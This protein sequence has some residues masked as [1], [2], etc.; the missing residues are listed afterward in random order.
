[1]RVRQVGFGLLRA[2]SD[3]FV[4]YRAALHDDVDLDSK[5]NHGA[6]EIPAVFFHILPK[7]RFHSVSKRRFSKRSQTR[8][9]DAIF[10]EVSG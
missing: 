3:L 6:F 9:L 7:E 8:L 2:F 1:M 4:D 5:H 10:N